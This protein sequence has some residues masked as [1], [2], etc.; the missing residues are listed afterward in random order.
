MKHDMLDA[1]GGCRN[2]RFAGMS[3]T[4]S[5]VKIP[6]LAA[7][8]LGLGSIWLDEQVLTENKLEYGVTF[9]SRYILYSSLSAERRSSY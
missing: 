1:H 7:T 5:F 8:S 4:Q 6:Q 9:D 2:L 3:S